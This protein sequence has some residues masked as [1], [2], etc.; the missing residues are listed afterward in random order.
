MALDET[1]I[2]VKDPSSTLTVGL[3]WQ[4]VAARGGT[5]QSVAWTVPAGLTK[6]SE[7]INT[8]SLVDDGTTYPVGQV[9]LVRLSGG[10]ALADIDIVCRITTAS[11]DVDERTIT[12][13]VRER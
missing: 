7:G 2:W 5:L 4:D 13:Q 1:R 9:A 8:T 11:G 12:V 6:V 10:A 3:W